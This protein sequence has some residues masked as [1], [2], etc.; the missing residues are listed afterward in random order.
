MYKLL[1]LLFHRLKQSESSI[2]FEID[3]NHF[4]FSLND[5]SNINFSA[6]MW[7]KEEGRTYIPLASF[8]DQNEK[9]IYFTSTILGMYKVKFYTTYTSYS[10]D[11]RK[12]HIIHDTIQP[13][14][15]GT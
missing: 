1:T 8:D 5:G 2:F 14:N 6:S 7:K 15:N 3:S 13:L 11:I 12:S 9:T 4:L 10:G